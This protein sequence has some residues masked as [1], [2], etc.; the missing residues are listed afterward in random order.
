MR[1]NLL[2]QNAFDLGLKRLAAG[3]FSA[4]YRVFSS[5]VIAYPGHPA[6]L[7]ALG[8]AARRM[9][10]LEDAVTHFELALAAA[11]EDANSH[12]GLA[13]TLDDLD[14]PQ[15]ALCH[16]D[17]AI[18]LMPA[19]LD[20]H[21][22][23]GLL[24]RKMGRFE[25]A[26]AGLEA[27]A[28]LAPFQAEAWLALGLTRLDMDLI[29]PAI[30]AL[31]RALALDPDN[32]VALLARAQAAAD[33]GNE[34]LG[35]YNRLRA[36][37]RLT[38]PRALGEAAALHKI[39][40]GREAIN[41]LEALL[42]DDPQWKDGQAALANLR[43]Q[44]EDPGDF[45]RG[46]GAPPLPALRSDYLAALARAGRYHEILA[47][48]DT[49]GWDEEFLL[50]QALAASEIGDMQRA[51]ATFRRFHA[52][53][54]ASGVAYVRHLLRMRAFDAAAGLSERLI[55]AGDNAAWPY[56]TTSWRL[57]GDCRWQ[58]LED[59][60]FVKTVDLS[61]IVNLDDLECTL[62]QLHLAPRA[63]INQSVLGGTQTDGNLFLHGDPVLQAL[64]RAVNVAVDDYIRQLPPAEPAHP[65]LEKPREAFRVTGAWSV[66]LAPGGI[67]S[68]HTHPQGWISSAFYV[69]MPSG[70]C[71]G[72][73]IFGKPPLELGLEL[74]PILTIQP[75]PGKL[76]LFPSYF[77]HGTTEFDEGDRLSVAFDVNSG[78]LKR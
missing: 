40:A 15:D 68:S 12:N 43:W 17:R 3:D 38:H 44:W 31:D 11:P 47:V 69:R 46:Y 33:H 35:Y 63:P 16:Y 21:V 67:H 54:G 5:I 37:P 64:R 42:A 27:A 41:L 14:R 70:P 45:L 65:L 39:G 20:A 7:Q 32:A 72:D 26:E 23:R 2:L 53:G 10:R 6:A 18:D 48:I 57:L 22:N 36:F 60:A 71:S 66:L 51:E 29:V 8:V 77:W 73:L 4:A 50:I 52:V 49:G 56:L 24:L 61:A 76:V 1:E 19:G 30:A 13:N 59:V 25:E 75:A 78:R 55:A 28:Q 58:H 9:G 74:S 62:R 34:A